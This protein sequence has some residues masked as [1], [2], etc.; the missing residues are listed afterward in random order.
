[1]AFAIVLSF[2]ISVT[3]RPDDSV[4]WK[5]QAAKD[6]K[7][8]L[9]TI[10]FDGQAPKQLTCDDNR[11]RC[12][13]CRAKLPDL[14][15]GS[16]VRNDEVALLRSQAQWKLA[17]AEAEQVAMSQEGLTLRHA[18]R[19]RWTSKWLD[20]PAGASWKS[21][22]LE[23]EIDLFAN[24]T[25]EVIVD[26]SAKP[27]VDADGVE[28]DWY[29]RCMIAILDARRWV[30]A[31]RSGINHI[32]W[33]KRDA[34]HLLTSS[35]EGRSWSKLNRWFDG[36][37]IEGL[38]YEDGHT[39]SEP[40]LYRMPNGDLILQFWRTSYSSGTKQLRSTDDG[41]TW[42]VDHDRI[43]VQGMTDVPGDLAIG[44]ED[45]FI[46]PE[47]LGD[48]Y[49]AFQYWDYRG[50]LGGH[51]SGTFLARSTDNG[52]S[53]RFLSW[54]GPL[55]DLRDR[56]SKATFEPAIEYVGNRTIVAVLRDAEV[57]GGGGCHTWQTVS[58]DMGASFAP[59]VDIHEQVDGG[60]PNGLWQRARLYKE[61]NPV[62][63]FSNELDYA[64]GEGRLWGFGLH[65]NGG[66]HTRKPVVYYSDDN[67]KTW[68]GPESLH[69]AMH[70][71]TDT[72][73]GDIKRRVDGT[74]VAATYFATRHSA[75]AD[76]EQYTFGGQ[77]VRLLVEVDRNGDGRP[78][79]DS[80]WREIYGGQ[81]TID[82]PQLS[83][84][85][86]RARL[87]LRAPQNAPPPT[88]RSLHLRAQP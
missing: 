29:G 69:G 88:V 59:L 55:G 21:V 77:R 38:P 58:T 11:D 19:G 48:V 80:G 36:T 44:T 3:G 1:M 31:I 27:F 68:I 70:L 84:P 33:G 4:N 42:L 13:F 14:P 63:Q 49:M 8:D 54:L 67:G 41:K 85:R 74:F 61:S 76:T 18:P 23:T 39:H 75:V 64:R 7:Q 22:A 82:V 2:G 30:M 40:G 62:F 56:S 16:A 5:R 65:S 20:A 50:K 53:Y 51:L 9:S 25:I 86:W 73:Y 17:T 12:V 72:G 79:A 87:E 46:D 43:K 34:I 60:I 37:A 6:A 35:D 71:G 26:G 15:T 78:D 83:G 28:H 52:K 81:R 66:G 47:N 10:V 32:Q 45:W 57:S 24:K